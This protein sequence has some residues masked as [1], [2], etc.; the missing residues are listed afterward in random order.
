MPAS[1]LRSTPSSLEWLFNLIE[2]RTS[3]ALP[4]IITTQRTGDALEQQ[5]TG[6]GNSTYGPA[7]VRRLRDNRFFLKVRCRNGDPENPANEL[8][9]TCEQT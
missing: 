6:K 3:R 7:I 1:T 4:M 8:S 9:Q 5:L 2:T